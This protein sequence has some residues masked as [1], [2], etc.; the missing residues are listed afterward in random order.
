MDSD[1]DGVRDDVQRWI[2]ATYPD[3]KNLRNVLMY[4]ARSEQGLLQMPLDRKQIYTYMNDDTRYECVLFVNGFLYGYAL[5][6]LVM[7]KKKLN[8]VI[9]NT[10]E[11]KEAYWTRSNLGSGFYMSDKVNAENCKKLFGLEMQLDVQKSGESIPSGHDRWKDKGAVLGV[12]SDND[13]VRDDVQWW[14]LTTYPNNFKLRNILMY[15]ARF[16]LELIEMPIEDKRKYLVLNDGAENTCV[17]TANGYFDRPRPFG[18]GEYKFAKSSLMEVILNTEERR[19]AYWA[20]SHH[21][22][23]YMEEPFR[24]ITEKYC[25]QRFGLEIQ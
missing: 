19:E 17:H 7:P 3:D 25:K 24:E 1:N 14:I 5:Q 22:K 9:L 11:R 23:F 13:G 15:M 20:G 21:D 16:H 4:V 6:D 8:K 10:P 2:L 18:L 12:D